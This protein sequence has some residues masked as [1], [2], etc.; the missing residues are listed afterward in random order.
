MESS[1]P[2]EAFKLRLLNG[3][4]SLL[5]YAGL[6]LGAETVAEA[7][8]DEDVRA[9]AD[10]LATEDL[11]PTLPDVPGI[12]VD[13]YRAALAERWANPRIAHRL[14][15]IALDGQQKLPARFGG[16]DGQ[17]IALT[18]AA[19]LEHDPRATC[20]CS[21]RTARARAGVAGADRRR[22]VPR[23][24]AASAVSRHALHVRVQQRSAAALTET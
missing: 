16:L 21:G 12:P 7:W 5:A 11:V 13:E 8:A 17:W 6:A 2:H 15:Q 1:A 3:T 19:W 23:R 4:H 22:R 18:L 9:A 14:E 24:A 10:R 20:R